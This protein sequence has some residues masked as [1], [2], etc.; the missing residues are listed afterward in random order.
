MA[1]LDMML[2]LLV[3]AAVVPWSC[4]V[5][6]PPANDEC[7]NGCAKY[8]KEP[9]QL[10]QCKDE[11]ALAAEFHAATEG[12]EACN[13]ACEVKG[14]SPAAVGVCM[15]ACTMKVDAAVGVVATRACYRDCARDSKGDAAALKKCQAL[16]DATGEKGAAATE[17]EA[18]ETTTAAAAAPK[19]R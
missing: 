9:L 8:D 5:L 11:C 12:L 15:E 3:V 17:K 13:K 4:A 18:A 7:S 19:R 2:A 10:A 1:Q 14:G 6:V 16:C